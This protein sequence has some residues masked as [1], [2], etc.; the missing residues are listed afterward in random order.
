MNNFIIIH[1]GKRNLAFTISS[2]EK[3][4][5]S[6]SYVIVAPRSTMEELDIESTKIIFYDHN[7]SIGSA[8]NQGVELIHGDVVF[9]VK[10]G[11]YMTYEALEALKSC[12]LENG[13]GIAMPRLN[14]FFEKQKFPFKS[15]EEN[16]ILKEAYTLSNNEYEDRSYT[17]DVDDNLIAFTPY[18]FHTVGG[19]DNEIKSLPVLYKDYLIRCF[20]S[21]FS[22]VVANDGLVYSRNICD[23]R[24]LHGEGALKLEEKLGFNFNGYNIIKN[25]LTEFIIENPYE[26]LN[27]LEVGCGPG[28][29]LMSI[30]NKFKYANLTGLELDERCS[31]I[32]P[33]FVDLK[34]GDYLDTITELEDDSF[35]YIFCHNVLE[36]MEDPWEFLIR[37]RKKLSPSGS[38]VASIGNINHISILGEL[39]NGLFIYKNGGILDINNV[40]FFTLNT[41]IKLF[42]DTG[43]EVS[44]IGGVRSGGPGEDELI[45]EIIDLSIINNQIQQPID[46]SAQ[47]GVLLFNLI[48]TKVGE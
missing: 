17:K 43:Y 12:A 4:I 11:C 24:E 6:F 1:E 20:N 47:M 31:S 13:T 19:F 22:G 25:E 32:A 42:N 34:I 37:C 7:I 9:L 23:E 33:P 41:M 21:G 18:S 30:K 14:S 16:S 15:V 27:I 3:N 45:K 8:L 44:R 35:D 40:R 5:K 29:T 28:Y 38:L 39:L 26:D 46:L 48:C 10:A 2:L 36:K